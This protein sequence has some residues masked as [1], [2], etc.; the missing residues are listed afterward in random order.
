M[1]IDGVELVWTAPGDHSNVGRTA[2]YDVRWSVNPIT[3]EAA[4]DGANAVAGVPATLEAGERQSLLINRSTLPAD[5]QVYFAVRS[6]NIAGTDALR[7]NLVNLEVFEPQPFEIELAVGWNLISV[8]VA[9]LTESTSLLVGD[10]ATVWTWNGRHEMAT[11]LESNTGYWVNSES[12]GTLTLYG[13][14]VAGDLTLAKEWN[15]VGPIADTLLDANTR[16]AVRA[17]Y[18]W[19]A[20]IGSMLLID[21]ENTILRAGQG[22]WIYSLV[23]GLIVNDARR[24]IAMEPPAMRS[25]SD[26]LNRYEDPSVSIRSDLRI[27]FTHDM[28]AE[29]FQRQDIES[30]TTIHLR[31]FSETLR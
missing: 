30:E 13:R 14:P 15:L 1:R 27:Q 28:M 3:G 31:L 9:M 7:S 24:S 5:T 29:L 17:V 8:P 20:E 4:F 19:N 11:I 26:T 21:A 18:T 12:G 16:A 23:D 22:Y 6:T 10:T 2:T 25:F